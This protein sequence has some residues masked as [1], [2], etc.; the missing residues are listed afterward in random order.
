M[1]NTHLGSLRH[2]LTFHEAYSTPSMCALYLANVFEKIKTSS[3]YT[4]A[5]RQWGC[6][7]LCIMC[8]NVAG[9][10]DSPNGMTLYS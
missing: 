4:I 10:F 8:M 5:F 3:R 2:N 7:I 6:S 1:L 9:A